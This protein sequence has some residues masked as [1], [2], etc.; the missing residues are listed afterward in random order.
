MPS[1]RTQPADTFADTDAGQWLKALLATLL[2]CLVIAGL[3]TVM[4]AGDY[5]VNLRI[6]LGFGLSIV[7]LMNLTH[8]A[9]PRR[10]ERFNNL[11]GL[12]LGFSLGMAHLLWLGFGFPFALSG[13]E[14]WRAL[15]INPGAGAGVQ[16]DCLLPVLF[17][18]PHSLAEPA[19]GRAAGSRP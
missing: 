4:N 5:W 7:V 18:L 16:S 11:L 13:A 6:S 15:A 10:S 19:G 17:A 1:T 12:V 3:T 8:W 14:L 9:L 2:A